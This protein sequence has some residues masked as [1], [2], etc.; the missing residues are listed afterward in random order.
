MLK[1]LVLGFFGTIAL[2][3]IFVQGPAQKNGSKPE[4]II[5]AAAGGFGNLAQALETGSST[6]A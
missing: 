4:D 1:W 5:N 3:I 2:A 6:R